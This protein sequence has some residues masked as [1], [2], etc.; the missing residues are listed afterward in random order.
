MPLVNRN[1]V[2]K[3]LINIRGRSVQWSHVTVRILT[4]GDQ[5]ASRDHFRF[6]V[7]PRSLCSDRHTR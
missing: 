5:N 3:L 1:K 6:F 4:L 7:T 2:Q